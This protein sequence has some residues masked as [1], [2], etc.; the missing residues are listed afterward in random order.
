MSKFLRVKDE[1]NLF[2]DDS[3]KAILN[4]DISALDKYKM[5]R[6]A[7]LNMLKEQSVMKNEINE[8]KDTLSL[9]LSKLE[10]L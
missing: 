10:K 1:K 3:N 2:R 4:A 7:K 8:I 6:D 9:I 5:E